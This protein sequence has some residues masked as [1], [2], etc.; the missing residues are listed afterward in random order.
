MKSGLSIISQA[1]FQ[2]TKDALCSRHPLSQE[3]DEALYYVAMRRMPAAINEVTSS[4]VYPTADFQK[5]FEGMPD[6]DR[7]DVFND[8]LARAKESARGNLSKDLED[9]FGYTAAAELLIKALYSTVEDFLGHRDESALNKEFYETL[10]EE[11]QH[12]IGVLAD[13]NKDLQDQ[14]LHLFG[15]LGLERQTSLLKDLRSERMQHKLERL[16]PAA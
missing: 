15:K 12:Y 11:A 2:A 14:A 1:V 10:V 7:R 6:H 4:D 16:E 5:A 8:Q 9:M 3:D 13:G